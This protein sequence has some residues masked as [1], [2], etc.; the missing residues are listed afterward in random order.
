[1]VFEHAE[2]IR[3]QYTDKYVVVDAE[4]PELARFQNVVGLVHTVNMS[5]RALVEFLDYHNNISW[6]D[7]EIDYLKVVDKP[8]PKEEKAEAKPKPAAKKPAVAKAAPG[9]EKKL[10]PLELA[11]MQGAAKSAAPAKTSDGEPSAGK[12][13]VAEIMAA[14]RVPKESGTTAKAAPAKPPAPKAA[15]AKVDRSKMSVADMIAAARAEKGGGAAPAPVATA[16]AAVVAPAAVEEPAVEE[17]VAE[18]AVV[19]T[20]APSKA[21]EASGKVDRSTMSVEDMIAW[22]REHDGQ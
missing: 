10:S 2:K 7:I 8:P 1:M 19:E 14:A 17:T 21:P 20:P 11:R 12:K 22:C 13:S 16:P 3:E 9:G 15:P 5:G 4:R 6:Y 18:E